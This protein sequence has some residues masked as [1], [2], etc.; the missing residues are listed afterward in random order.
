MNWQI[1]GD[2]VRGASHKRNGKPNQDAWS[3]T[4][5]EGCTVLAVADGHGSSK[6]YR[7]DVGAKL[8]VQ[9]ALELLNDFAHA[10]TGSN[11]RQIKQAADYLPSQL[12]QAWRAAVDNVDEGQ[13]IIPKERYSIYGTTLLA[14]LISADY[15]LYLQIGDGDLL[16]L[17]EDGQLH[18]PLPKNTNLIANETYSLCEEKAIY[19]VEFSL[20]FFDHKPLPALIFLATDGYA[21]S[22]TDSVDFQ[23]AV[24]DFQLHIATH[25]SDKIQDC[26]ADWLNETSEQGSGDDVTV[27]MV[28]L[29]ADTNVAN[30]EVIML[31]E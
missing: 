30:G 17:T 28:L 19:H 31:P 1:I 25:G 8:A 27:A 21:N 2:S 23:Q 20:Q 11:P 7:S 10:D 26:L 13:T 18:T 12:V 22:F 16:V 15:A 6:H 5:N 4:Q 14:V 9:A 29:T 3:F 24:Q